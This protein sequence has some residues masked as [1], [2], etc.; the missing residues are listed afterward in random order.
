ME[1]NFRIQ[2]NSKQITA[3]L[4]LKEVENGKIELK[5]TIREYLPESKQTWADKV[6]V[7]QLLN[8]SSGITG[9][10]SP[11]I[12]KPGTNYRYSNP[13][14]SLLG[15]ILEKVTGETYV[16]LAN[17]LFAELKMNNTYCYE[18][19]MTPNHNMLVNG[20]LISNNEPELVDFYSIERGRTKEEW[21]NF[22]PAGGIVSNLKDL[23]TWDVNFHNGKIVKPETYK[24]DNQL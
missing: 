15:K 1:D 17:N 2:S 24:Q 7:H 16:N 22:V 9:L 11:L 14:Y 19:G 5:N 20:Y 18:M 6:T 10:D 12:F 3:V 8:M 21:D 4:I 23:N 13:A